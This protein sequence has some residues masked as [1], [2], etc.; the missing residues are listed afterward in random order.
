MDGAPGLEVERELEPFRVGERGVGYPDEEAAICESLDHAPRALQEGDEVAGVPRVVEVD[1]HWPLPS[2]RRTARRRWTHRGG[3]APQAKLTVGAGRPPQANGSAS[4]GARIGGLALVGVSVAGLVLG[5]LALG[6]EPTTADRI[7]P[8]CVFIILVLLVAR[9]AARAHRLAVDAAVARERRRIARELHDG[10]AQELVFVV[11]ECSRLASEP[12]IGSIAEAAQTALAEARRAMLAL[13]RP[14]GTPLAAELEQVARRAA[15]RAGLRLE[16][17]LDGGIDLPPLARVELSRILHEA[18]ANT[19]RHA[20]ATGV[21]VELSGGRGVRLTVSDDGVGFD[22]DHPGAVFP[23][24]GILG[25]RERVSIIGG[26][27]SIVSRPFHG[28]R[29]EVLIP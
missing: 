12:G 26:E 9:G 15:D 20:K 18:I 23:G 6:T 5:S 29:V 2:L 17:R 24:F 11:T 10:L 22:P 7:V 8:V 27:L 28:T 4:I 3:R 13:R 1:L 21:C 25:M 14:A 19:A 16:L